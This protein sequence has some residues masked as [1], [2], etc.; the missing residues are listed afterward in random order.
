MKISVTNV[1]KLLPALLALLSF[2]AP[3]STLD[4]DAQKVGH[5]TGTV[6]HEIGHGAKEA[7]L[8]VVHAAEK[9]GKEIG[10]AAEAGGKA[11]M[12]A[13]KGAK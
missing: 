13:A 11:F 10:T 12:K 5:A 3:A 6:V 9:T 4:Q 7:G 1:L 8:T 2:S